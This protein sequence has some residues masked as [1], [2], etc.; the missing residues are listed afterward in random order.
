MSKPIKPEYTNREVIEDKLLT[1]IMDEG[2]VAILL[3]EH[4]LNFLCK[5]LRK[6][7]E[8]ASL[9]PNDSEELEE[10]RADL[11]TLLKSAF[12]KGGG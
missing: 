7:A 10:F 5:M 2:K 1:A 8:Y 6:A 11:L 3:T 4:E 12:P 9:S